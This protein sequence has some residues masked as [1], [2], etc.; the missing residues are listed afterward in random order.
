M[1]KYYS[2]NIDGMHIFSATEVSNP[3]KVKECLREKQGRPDWHLSVGGMDDHTISCNP[4]TPLYIYGAK[5]TD[6][7][8]NQDGEIL[9]STYADSPHADTIH[10]RYLSQW[11]GTTP[12]K[13]G[14][15]T[16]TPTL[17]EKPQLKLF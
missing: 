5:S 14:Y 4:C 12:D 6:I 7:L 8:I 11:R 2:L 16:A 3:H 1:S 17:F 9:Y 10:E 15:A 13:I